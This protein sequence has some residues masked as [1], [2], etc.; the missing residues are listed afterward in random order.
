MNLLNKIVSSGRRILSAI[1]GG[2]VK[3]PKASKPSRPKKNARPARSENGGKPRAPQGRRVSSQRPERGGG[4]SR[5]P[6]GRQKISADA[7]APKASAPKEVPAPYSMETLRAEL[8]DF[9]ELGLSDI[10]LSAVKDMG[11]STPTPIQSKTVPIIL[12]GADVIGTAQTGTGKTAAFALPIVNMIGAHETNPRV[13]VLSPTRELA[14]QTAEA[15]EKFSKY[16]PV[17]TLLVQGGVSMERQI[18]ALKAGVDIVVATPGRLLDLNRNRAISLKSVKW[19]VLDEVDRMF[20]MGFIEDV[21]NII[22]LCPQ[23]RQ[24]L[25]FSATMPDA[26]MRLSK[27]ALKD[28]QRLDTGIV[29]S[30]ADTIEHFIYPVDGIQK[31]DL[32]IEFLKS[33]KFDSLIVFTRTRM[34]ADR[35]GEWLIGHDYKVSVLHSDRTQR[36]RDK[37]LGDF[38]ERKTNIL[39]ATDIASRGL[40]I[41]DVQYV[42]NYN[43][44]EHSEDYVHR[45][46]RTGRANKDGIAVTFFSSDETMFLKR[47]EEFIGSRIERRKLE[48]FA[49]RNEPILVEEVKRPRKR[50]R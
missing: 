30:P 9:A 46:G 42:V 33:V 5:R 41:N 12:T 27:W 6:Q 25:F 49:Y 8:P 19:L 24:T 1:K 17:E 48:G 18:A 15:F 23:N 35:I 45:I 31:Y 26:V 34:D 11:Y 7:I 13:L 44:P 20:D 36:E 4:K 21:S 32:L 29:H 43:V 50:N 22:R 2:D 28:P 37:A 3:K 40:D 16:S 47:I 14:S 10:V 39:V 38:K